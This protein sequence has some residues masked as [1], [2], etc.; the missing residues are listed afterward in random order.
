MTV[1]G[2][3]A[4]CLSTDRSDCSSSGFESLLNSVATSSA[5]SSLSVRNCDAPAMARL[6]AAVSNGQSPHTPWSAWSW[7]AAQLRCWGLTA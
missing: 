1:S 3:M 6:A 4:H 2:A 5:V 7:T